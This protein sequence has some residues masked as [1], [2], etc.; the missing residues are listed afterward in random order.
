MENGFSLNMRLICLSCLCYYVFR[1]IRIIVDFIV[2]LLD[3]LNIRWKKKLKEGFC[4][5]LFLLCLYWKYRE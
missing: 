2:G 1:V 4:E 3:M 5:E